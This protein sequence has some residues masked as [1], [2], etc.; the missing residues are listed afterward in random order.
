MQKAQENSAINEQEMMA[1]REVRQQRLAN[2]LNE[3]DEINKL[4]SQIEEFELTAPKKERSS[5]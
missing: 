3:Q 4:R 1:E 5:S 2:Q